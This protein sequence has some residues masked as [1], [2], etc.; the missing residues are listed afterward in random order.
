MGTKASTPRSRSKRQK[1]ESDEPNPYFDLVKT[2]GKG[3]PAYRL[4][5]LG[6]KRIEDLGSLHASQ[7]EIASDLGVCRDVLRSPQN[8]EL[9]RQ[10]YEKGDSAGKLEI[11]QA[12]CRGIRN[13]NAKI[14]MFMAS[15]TNGGGLGISTA[16]KPD[17]SSSVLTGLLEGI[18]QLRASDPEDDDEEEDEEA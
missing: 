12:L 3:R 7:E 6:I 18:E 11:R 16:P 17:E 5:K 9:Y 1:E 2:G 13:D 4:N 8:N 14:V 10:A 15:A